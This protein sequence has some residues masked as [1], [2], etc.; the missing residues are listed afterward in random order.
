MSGM[1]PQEDKEFDEGVLGAIESGIAETN[2]KPETEDDPVETIDA[3]DTAAEPVAETDPESEPAAEPEEEVDLDAPPTPKLDKV[4]DEDPEEKD[5]EKT[6]ADEKDPEELESGEAKPSDPPDPETE[7]EPDSIPKEAKPSDEFGELEKDAPV[8]SRE[9]FDTM[10]SRFD[11]VSEKLEHVSSQNTQWMETIQSTK[12]TPDQLGMSLEYLKDINEGTPESMERAY[13]TMMAEL[14][15]LGKAL[16]KKTPGFNP[17]DGFDDLKK[18]VAEGY[19]EEADALEIAESRSKSNF[20]KQQQQAREQEQNNQ[21]QAPTT[22]VGVQ[23]LT[24]LG[25]RLRAADPNYKSKLPQIEQIVDD[26]VSSGADP[27]VWAALVEKGYNRIQ[28]AAPAPKPKVSAVPNPIRPSSS[29][30]GTRSKEAGNI[31]EAID[32]ALQNMG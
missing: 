27:S 17:L 12:A 1:N 10:K 11:E 5:A 31:S 30:A 18:K 15:V 13:G 14:E 9:R 19:L 3:T 26:V 22:D 8:K 6:D 28:A 2:E 21:Q 20:S 4:Y 29:G 32:M 25:T 16:G 24:E 23:A 7:A